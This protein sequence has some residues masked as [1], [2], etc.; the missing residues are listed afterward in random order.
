MKRINQGN[1]Y[2]LFTNNKSTNKYIEQFDNQFKNVQTSQQTEAP[3]IDHMKNTLG[4][5]EASRIEQETFSNFKSYNSQGLINQQKPNYLQDALAN[6]VSGGL[7]RNEIKSGMNG[8]HSSILGKVEQLPQEQK[9]DKKEV[10]VEP[11]KIEEPIIEVPI[12]PYKNLAS[13]AKMFNDGK[14]IKLTEKTVASLKS[15]LTNPDA[16]QKAKQDA[17]DIVFA[18]GNQ[19]LIGD[20][21]L[22]LAQNI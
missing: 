17:A 14:N 4:F 18:A 19:D 10:I 16:T 22:E 9:I 8:V 5:I 15:A 11:I 6:I 13:M 3:K 20:E 1:E 12:D 7:E 2:N 21:L